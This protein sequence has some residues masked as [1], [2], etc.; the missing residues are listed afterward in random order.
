MTISK[1]EIKEEIGIIT[2]LT[3]VMRGKP[4]E[5]NSLHLQDI[6]R[7]TGLT[8]EQIKNTYI[9]HLENFPIYGLH[10]ELSPD[11]QILSCTNL[12][13]Q[14]PNQNDYV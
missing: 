8:P 3:G 7:I 9:Q 13:K 4:N 14:Y 6:Q 1:R 2:M 11:K 12:S 5:K 10:F